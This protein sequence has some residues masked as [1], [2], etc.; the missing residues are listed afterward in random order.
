MMFMEIIHVCILPVKIWG[1]HV[2]L[3]FYQRLSTFALKHFD[4][5]ALL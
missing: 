5:V 2:I 3:L 4:Y 1:L